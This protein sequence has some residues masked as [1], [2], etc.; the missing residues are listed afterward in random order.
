MKRIKKQN[1]RRARLSISIDPNLNKNLE[2]I[3]NNKSKYIE[4]A[5][6]DYFSKSGLEMSKIKISE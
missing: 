6:L 5:L 4:Y 3:T 2:N 1:E